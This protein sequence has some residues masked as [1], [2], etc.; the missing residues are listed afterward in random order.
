MEINTESKDLVIEVFYKENEKNSL[1]DFTKG[2]FPAERELHIYTWMDA[3]LR[4][5]SNFLHYLQLI[6]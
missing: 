1:D 5:I 6:W 4:E 3:T 2:N